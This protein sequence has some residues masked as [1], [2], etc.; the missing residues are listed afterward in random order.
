[1]SFIVEGTKIAPKECKYGNPDENSLSTA[2]RNIAINCLAPKSGAKTLGDLLGRVHQGNQ[3]QPDVENGFNPDPYVG[4][5][6]AL[7]WG[8][9]PIHLGEGAYL[10][11]AGHP[12]PAI[13]GSLTSARFRSPPHRRC[14][15]RTDRR[16][17]ACVNRGRSSRG[18]VSLDI[19]ACQLTIE[20][21]PI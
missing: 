20:P 5:F 8:R 21:Q 10:A 14:V 11:S 4:H 13:R 2:D 1:M 7:L 19:T 6:C 3:P 17:A 12:M 16:Q 18:V 15:I 9:L